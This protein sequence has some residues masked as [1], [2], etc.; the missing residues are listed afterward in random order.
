[1]RYFIILFWLVVSVSAQA[2]G[3]TDLIRLVVDQHILSGVA[4][5]ADSSED[6]ANAR[7][8]AV[9]RMIR[10]WAGPMAGRLMPG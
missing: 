8:T 5:L 4:H 3:R 10:R 2:D 9:I 7:K 1:M 6:L